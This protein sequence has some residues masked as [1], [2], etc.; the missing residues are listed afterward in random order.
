M[1]FASIPFQLS[2]T[3]AAG[4][5]YIL[6]SEFDWFI[7]VFGIISIILSSTLKEVYVKP[8]DFIKGNY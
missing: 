6:H 1:L 8:A 7:P 5:T 2:L 3:F 4:K